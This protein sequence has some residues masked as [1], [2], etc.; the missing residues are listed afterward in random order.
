MRVA[1][2]LRYPGGKASMTSV[3]RQIR[4]SNGLNGHAVAEPFAG[5]AGAAIPALP[6]RDTR[7]TYQRP[8]LGDSRLLAFGGS[9]QRG[10]DS[11]TLRSVLSRSRSGGGGGM[12]T[13][14]RARRVLSAGSRPSA[15][16]AVTGPASSRTAALI[17]GIEQR[18]RWK[19]DA[20]FNKDTLRERLE[21]IADERDRIFVS[22]TSMGSTF[23]DTLDPETATL[24]D[25]TLDPPL[26]SGRRSTS[27]G[28]SRVARGLPR[29]SGACRRLMGS[30]DLRPLRGDPCASP[31]AWA[32]AEVAAAGDAL[33]GL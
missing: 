32:A 22:S 15:S 6:S 26:R 12:S 14:A 16:T 3:L 18:G 25:H 7:D 30:R 19:I 2:P 11:T 29:S 17:G 20:R 9:R 33:Y 10:A 13:G 4:E 23:I 31:G 27:T 21:R 1:S 24:F 28:R 8:R 5:G